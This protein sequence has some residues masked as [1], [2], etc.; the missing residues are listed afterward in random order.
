MKHL[1]LLGLIIA[2]TSFVVA[3]S[4]AQSSSCGSDADTDA[5][6]VEEDV[7]TVAPADSSDAMNNQNMTD[8]DAQEVVVEEDEVMED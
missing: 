8:D 3:P 5:V 1:S 6:V 7:I 2:L 4:Y